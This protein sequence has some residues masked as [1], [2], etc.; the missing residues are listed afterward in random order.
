MGTA[1]ELPLARRAQLA[2]VAH[3]RHLY[4]DYDRLL[5]LKSFH[6]ARSA[7]EQ[8]T[9]AK[10]IE[11]R[12]DDENGQTVLEDVFR[13]VIVIS[14]DDDSE[15]EEGVART[16]TH[17]Q[18]AQI[19]LGDPRTHEI[20]VQPVS[21]AQLSRPGSL[22]DSSEEAPP[23]FRIVSK[24]PAERAGDRR[25]FS[26]YQAWNRALNR[27][28][29]E[30]QNT[31]AP[32]GDGSAERRSPRYAK[33]PAVVQESADPARR[34]DTAPQFLDTVHKTTREPILGD[35]SRQRAPVP[36]AVDRLS[37]TNHVGAQERHYHME[38]QQ[39]YPKFGPNELPPVLTA[40]KPRDVRQLED[41]PRSGPDALFPPES[42]RPG[43]RANVPF[44]RLPQPVFVNRLKELHFGNETQTERGTDAPPSSRPK[45]GIAPSD[46]VL[47]SVENSWPLE[48]RP[49]EG[50]LERQTQRLSLRSVTPVRRQGDNFQHAHVSMPDS[51]NGQNPKRR[52]LNHYAAPHRNTRLDVREANPPGLPISQGLSPRGH[53]RRDE[54]VPE[55]RSQN[56]THLGL[57]YPSAVNQPS[58]PGIYEEKP[59]VSFVPPQASMGAREVIDLT[60]VVDSPSHVSAHHSQPDLP[61][62]GSSN[63]ASE[64]VFRTAEFSRSDRAFHGDCSPHTDRARPSVAERSHA[65][66]W[67]PVNGHHLITGASADGRLYAD[68]FVR[69][70]DIQEVRPVQHYVEHSGPLAQ[71]AGEKLNQAMRT[72]VSSHY[73][74][75][76]LQPHAPMSE[77]RQPSGAA[78]MTQIFH[79]KASHRPEDTFQGQRT[80][81]SSRQGR[82]GNGFSV[83]R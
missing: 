11:W 53:Y 23:G 46:Y 12:G 69:P 73:V 16:D 80:D 43:Q 54:L 28:R 8:A 33:R 74:S 5:K 30:A 39:A 57:C 29:T 56:G 21:T 75:E 7:V 67:K 15:T 26:R 4:T 10:V 37:D 60:H 72:G 68:G 40:Q 51:P 6:E 77:Q 63:V 62:I 36:L 34:W 41:P 70:V 65:F 45:P 2:V 49:A 18:D 17:E 44:G 31:M 9:L 81:H 24:A 71:N 50:H 1:T 55:P 64:R 79:N 32:L 59:P 14:D 20:H 83:S 38:K 35:V 52:R 76:D 3:I 42:S 47:P 58:L 61:G 27:Y 13:E 66:L 19:S 82:P 78:W 48:N 22:Q 25:G